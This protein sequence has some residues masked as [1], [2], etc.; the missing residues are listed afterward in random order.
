MSVLNTFVSQGVMHV[1]IYYDADPQNP[2]CVVVVNRSSESP[3]SEIPAL[4]P[5]AWVHM[6]S[7]DQAQYPL[8]L[9][10]MEDKEVGHLYNKVAMKI[11]YFGY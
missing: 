7:M 3:F 1:H 10:W 9:K 2:F 8:L 5:N 11:S 6:G 4:T